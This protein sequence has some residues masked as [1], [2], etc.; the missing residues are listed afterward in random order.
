MT[1]NA[2]AVGRGEL[3]LFHTADF[4]LGSP[5][6]CL[7]MREGE[8]RRREQLDVFAAALGRA[9]ESGCSAILIAGDLF[10]CGYVDR[11]TVREV[12]GLLG[13][14]GMPVVIAPGNHDPMTRGGVYSM[15]DMPDNVFIFDS[16][17]M[18]YFDFPE[19]RLRVHG[20]AFES[21]RYTDDPLSADISLAEN[22]F[23]VL[24]AHADIY[25]PLSTYAPINLRQLEAIGFDYV[26]L[27]H[28][29]KFE[30][31][32]RLGRTLLSYSGFPIGRSFDECGKGGA[33]TVTLSSNTPLTANAERVILTDKQY[34]SER[35]DVTG[36][37]SRSDLI[38]AIRSHVSQKG[39]GSET[40]LRLYL[41]GSV[42]PALPTDVLLSATDLGL[43]MLD[44]RNDTL[45]VFDG[46]YL[47]N[48]LTLRG[49]LYRQLLPRLTDADPRERRVAAAA[50]RMG[51]AAIEGRSVL[52]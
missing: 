33:L 32:I 9:A 36:A 40:S 2:E 52:S 48:D 15:K 18:T 44:I 46:E 45:P 4:H 22:C 3:R 35:I 6:A 5:F 42:D 1:I 11:E 43:A 19:L 26:A 17:E 16:P 49:A 50:L 21:E 7:D 27:G 29:H 41:E 37:T 30:D 14:A 10:D 12:F 34:L 20:Y 24:L 8:A 23:N 31:P 39:Y 47:E 51:L 13:R 38:S 25:S 28:V